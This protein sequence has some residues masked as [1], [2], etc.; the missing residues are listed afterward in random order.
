VRLATTS[1]TPIAAHRS[2]RAFKGVVF[3]S[4]QITRGTTNAVYT[5]G[6]VSGTAAGGTLSG[7]Q[8]ATVT[9]GSQSGTR[10]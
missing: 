5:G 8:V 6:P 4:G 3:S 9:A 2:A 1:G 7:T 10:P